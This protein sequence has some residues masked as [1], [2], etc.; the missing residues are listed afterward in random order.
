MSSRS[1]P[2]RPRLRA[3]DSTGG[4]QRNKAAAHRRRPRGPR[5]G[6]HGHLPDTPQ[7]RRRRAGPRSGRPGGG[8][9]RRRPTAAAEGG[10]CRAPRR[11]GIRVPPVPEPEPARALAVELL[12]VTDVAPHPLGRS[13]DPGRDAAPAAQRARRPRTPQRDRASLGARRQPCAADRAAAQ[14]CTAFQD[15]ARDAEVGWGG[16]RPHR[17]QAPGVAAAMPPS[18]FRGASAPTRSTASGSAPRRGLRG[19]DRSRLARP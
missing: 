15:T 17:R 6:W 18:W 12:G 3:L 10:R 5:R 19:P 2:S 1:A 16:A 4:R 7:G 13:P 14:G 11:R 9:G 8:A